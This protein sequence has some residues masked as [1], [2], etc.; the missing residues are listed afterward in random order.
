M[1]EFVLKV[2]DIDDRGKDFTFPLPGAWLDTALAETPLKR[3]PRAGEGLFQL[4][5][6][7]NGHEILIR[8]QLDADLL[9][10]CSRC[11]GDAP[12]AVHTEVT[13][14]LTPGAE[15]EDELEGS[16][17]LE[18]EDLDRARFVGHEV[19]LDE[20]VREHLLLECPMQP[21][22]AENC[23]GIPIPAHVRPSEEDFGGS[24]RDPR[25]APLEQ[26][27]AKLSGKSDNKE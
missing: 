19:E 24:G 16:I 26:L 20:L 9:V 15:D 12:L 10:E 4:H 18:A 13:A 2:Q 3:D 21:L 25:L 6:Q 7:R 17:E 5:A 14:L 27:K 23:A 8:G 22:C 11:L 1:A